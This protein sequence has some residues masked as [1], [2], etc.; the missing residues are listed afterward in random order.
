MPACE[1]K[2]APAY[3]SAEPVNDGVFMRLEVRD[4]DRARAVDYQQVDDPRLARVRAIT[5]R[6]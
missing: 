2:F 5:L 4:G 1:W 3:K 6:R